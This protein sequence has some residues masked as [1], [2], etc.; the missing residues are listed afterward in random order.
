MEYFQ[1]TVLNT[2]IHECLHDSAK[3]EQTGGKTVTITVTALLKPKQKLV[4]QLLC[5]TTME[6][7]KFPIFTPLESQRHET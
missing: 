6:L 2:E 1:I 7:H 5:Q 4:Y 3:N